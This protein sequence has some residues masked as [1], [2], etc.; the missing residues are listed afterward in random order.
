MFLAKMSV[1]RWAY[2]GEGP[3]SGMLFYC[4]Y[5]IGSIPWRALSLVMSLQN[6][7]LGWSRPRWNAKEQTTLTL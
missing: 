2:I 1:C 6:Q 7:W 4:T 5:L 3:A